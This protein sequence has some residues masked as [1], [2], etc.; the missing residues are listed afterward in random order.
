MSFIHL[1]SRL[2]Q[3]KRG[4]AQG[5]GRR[6]RLTQIVP[7]GRPM[8]TRL[9][10]PSKLCSRASW[11]FRACPKR[12]HTCLDR[13]PKLS[14]ARGCWRRRAPRAAG[15]PEAAMTVYPELQ[16]S[17]QKQPEFRGANLAVFGGCCCP[18]YVR[19]VASAKHSSTIFTAQVVRGHMGSLFSRL[20]TTTIPSARLRRIR[21]I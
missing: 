4:V 9:L 3:T 20:Q 17:A 11:L 5:R 10:C 18:P 16:S 14:S 8:K 6:H 1:H 2:T 15:S 19:R 7:E 13:A 21:S 12:R